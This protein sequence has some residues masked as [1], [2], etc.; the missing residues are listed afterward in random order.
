MKILAISGSARKRRMTH[1]AIDLVLK[2]CIDEVEIISLAGKRI[3]GCI[4]CT[5]CA[6]DNKCKLNDDWCIIGDKMLDADIIIFGAP[7]YFGL[8][9]SLAHATLERTFSFRHR[10]ALLL[11]DKLGVIVSTCESRDVEDP[12]AKY[13]EMMFTYNQIKTIAKMQVNQYNQCYTCGFGMSCDQG[14]VVRK[15]GILDEILPCHLP[16][17]VTEQRETLEEIKSLRETLSQHGVKFNF[18]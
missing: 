9:N 5:E 18:K 16:P 14:I 15:N 17:E 2:N 3:N 12:V 6:V 10:G 4:G 13:I 8:V 1:N 7:N 11:K